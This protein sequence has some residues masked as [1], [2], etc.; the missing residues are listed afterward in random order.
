MIDTYAQMMQ[1]AKLNIY[2]FI[3]K[4][5]PYISQDTPT[6]SNFNSDTAQNN[7]TSL[8]VDVQYNSDPNVTV[9][10]SKSGVGN[11]QNGNGFTFPF[12]NDTG[13]DYSNYFQVNNLVT[14]NVFLQNVGKEYNNL[15]YLDNKINPIEAANRFKKVV[16]LF[17]VGSD[18]FVYEGTRYQIYGEQD[19]SRIYVSVCKGEY[20]ASGYP[21]FPLQVYQS[22]LNDPEINKDNVEFNRDYLSFQNGL[23]HLESLTPCQ[24]HPDCL[25]T[26]T[27]QGNYIGL[28]AQCP[29]F[30]KFLYEA[31]GGDI[32]LAQRIY[33]MI[34]YIISPRLDRKVLF[35]LQGVPNSGKTLLTSFIESLFNKEAVFSLDI[36]R[37]EGKFNISELIG[38]ALCISPDMSGKPLSRSLVSKLKQLTGKDT[39]GAERKHKSMVTFRN[40]AKILLGTNYPLFTAEKE[41][42]LAE[43]VVTIPFRYAPPKSQRDPSLLDKLKNETSAVVS[44]AIIL[45]QTMEMS[46]ADFAGEYEMNACTGNLEELKVDSFDAGS[47][48]YKFVKDNFEKDETS[49]VFVCDA[50]ELYDKKIGSKIGQ[51]SGSSTEK[52]FGKYVKEVFGARHDKKRKPREVIPEG[53]KRSALSCYIGIRCLVELKG[54]ETDK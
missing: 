36:E 33:Q 15:Q 34:G 42:G 49:L 7:P 13:I 48:M 46:G 14:G 44:K 17:T 37:Y 28:S 45:Y 47:L 26:Y 35:L 6:A 20:E 2:D 12:L 53:E 8:S 41:E 9:I 50:M 16:P 4:E 21:N 23:L 18:L 24:H 43:R 32:S 25:T 31:T 5:Q 22:L 1:K 27:I 3:K 54:E 52:L 10:D 40:T 19:F 38:K 11:Y 29:T 39:I 51:V 30:D